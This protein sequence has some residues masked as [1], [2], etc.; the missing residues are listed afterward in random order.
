MNLFCHE[1][2]LCHPSAQERQEA[3]G[4]LE[5]HEDGSI[6]CSAEREDGEEVS[7]W[8]HPGEWY[9]RTGER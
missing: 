2:G 7:V 3:A 9:Q 5:C 6:L 4:A 8:L 1:P